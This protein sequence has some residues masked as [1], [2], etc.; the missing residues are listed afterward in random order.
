MR[1]V[2]VTG[3][4]LPLPLVSVIARPPMASSAAAAAA[5]NRM[6]GRLYHGSGPGSA[7][8]ALFLVGERDLRAGVGGP[9]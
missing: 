2:S 7:L 4:Q 8:V 5:P 1:A 6:G 3:P 9:A